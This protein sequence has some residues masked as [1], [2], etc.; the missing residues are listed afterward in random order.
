VILVAD[1][2]DL[3]RVGLVQLLQAWDPEVDVVEAV[4]GPSLEAALATRDD[5]ALA[6]IDLVMPDFDAEDGVLRI[7]AARPALRVLVVSG[8]DD[9]AAM[10]RLLAA[11][12]AGFIPKSHDA[13]IA[14]HAV[15]LV[16]AG[17][18]YIPPET[19]AVVPAGSPRSTSASAMPD[20]LQ[21]EVAALTPRQRDT[22]AL[23][24]QGLPNKLIASRLGI[25]EATVKMHVTAL[26]RA[27]GVRSRAEL[28][29]ALG[30]DS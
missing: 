9:P 11:G 3:A 27:Y 18:R 23:L 28:L 5:W 24:R 2:H 10:A 14:L 7:L 22:L 20:A 25:S 19:L 26:L 6:V 17:G 30:R 15:E 16:L 12:V 29:V 21:A 1:D 8:L 13:R 4:D